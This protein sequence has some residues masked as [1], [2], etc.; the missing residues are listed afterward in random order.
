MQYIEY[1]HPVNG[2]E[3]KYVRKGREYQKSCPYPQ[4]NGFHII[5]TNFFQLILETFFFSSLT[6]SIIYMWWSIR[7]ERPKF[8]YIL[9]L[10][11]PTSIHLITLFNKLKQKEKE[12]C[13]THY[14]NFL[15]S[16][17]LIKHFKYDFLYFPSVEEELGYAINLHCF[18]N[19]LYM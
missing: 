4:P 9:E 15:H 11:T 5:M 17:R 12:N 13:S 10:E 1:I 14:C 8:C 19:Y 18:S 6:R 2:R 7:K 3:G 16:L